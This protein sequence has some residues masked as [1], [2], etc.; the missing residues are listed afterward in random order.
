M[1]CRGHTEDLADARAQSFRRVQCSLKEP[2]FLATVWVGR[3]RAAKASWW[4]LTGYPSR[5]LSLQ[6]PQVLMGWPRTQPQG[7]QPGQVI[8]ER[9]APS[10]WAGPRIRHSRGLGQHLLPG[11]PHSG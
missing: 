8:L 11:G 1:P 5:T 4:V 6:K 2:R 7:N 9:V 10:C 3:A